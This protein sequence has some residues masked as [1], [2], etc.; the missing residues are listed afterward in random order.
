VNN[1][2]KL[3]DFYQDKIFLTFDIDWAIDEVLLDTIDI[4]HP[5]L[6]ATIFATHATPVLETIREKDNLELGIHPN[7]R[8]LL[9]GAGGAYTQIIDDILQIVPEARS[10]R[11]HALVQGSD[12]NRYMH[13]KKIVFDLNTYIPVHSMKIIPYSYPDNIIQVPFFYEDDTYFSGDFRPSVNEYL[14][15]KGVKVFNFHP[16]HVFLNTETLE[17]YESARNVFHNYEGLKDYVNKQEY[18]TR[19]FLFELIDTALKKGFQFLK[20]QDIKRDLP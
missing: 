8:P 18:G 3:I 1:R 2:N 11:S 4:I 10:T 16:I 19:D 17:R 5:P 7:F 6:Q 13:E 20:I 9:N 12:I 14:S 15:A